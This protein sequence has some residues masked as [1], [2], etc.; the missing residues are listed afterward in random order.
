MIDDDKIL[1]MAE[2][3]PSSSASSSLGIRLH[4]VGTSRDGKKKSDN[5]KQMTDDNDS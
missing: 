5:K 4:N 3:R 2:R 1:K